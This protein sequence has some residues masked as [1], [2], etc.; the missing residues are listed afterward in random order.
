[1]KLVFN[2]SDREHKKTE[3]KNCNRETS[4]DIILS[5]I[6]AVSPVADIIRVRTGKRPIYITYFHASSI[7]SFVYEV[8]ML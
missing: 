4:P 7:F 1:M 3:T 8:F 5:V 6:C 2:T